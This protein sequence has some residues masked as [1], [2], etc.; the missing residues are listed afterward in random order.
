MYNDW[1]NLQVKNVWTQMGELPEARFSMGVVS[2]EGLIYIVGG[3]S[4]SSRHL[5]DLIR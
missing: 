2:F 1:F 5:P 3:C 4:S